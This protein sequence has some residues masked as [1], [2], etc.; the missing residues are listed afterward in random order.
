MTKETST[1]HLF[2]KSIL[3]NTVI[4]MA[5]FGSHPIAFVSKLEDIEEGTII[6]QAING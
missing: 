3:Q 2:Y 6:N 4:S 1:R 5:T